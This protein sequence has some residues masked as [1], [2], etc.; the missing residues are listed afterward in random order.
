[1]GL[2]GRRVLESARGRGKDTDSTGRGAL[3]AGSRINQCCLQ[4][5]S[6]PLEPAVA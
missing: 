5:C 2:S 1:M 3:R 4:Y 6:G